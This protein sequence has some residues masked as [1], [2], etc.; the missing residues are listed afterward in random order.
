MPEGITVVVRGTKEV[1]AAL[2]RMDREIDLGTLRA[3]KATQALAKKSIR[4]GMRGRPRW[5]HRGK[6]ARTGATV[7]LNLSP[8]VVS[9][10]GGPGRLTGKLARGVGGVRR[11]KP[12][13]GGGFAGGVGVGGGVRNLY[14]KRQ[15]AQYPYVRPGLRKAEPKMAAVWQIAWGRA[16]RI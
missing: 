14:K 6:S 11:P 7:K 4:S 5:D 13:P 3:L 9:K 8:H 1:E 2:T 15:E 12:V 16:T 10:G